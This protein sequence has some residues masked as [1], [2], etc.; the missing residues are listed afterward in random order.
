MSVLK[1]TNRNQVK[2]R[3][4]TEKKNVDWNKLVFDGW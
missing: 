2:S 4:G 3:G 1:F